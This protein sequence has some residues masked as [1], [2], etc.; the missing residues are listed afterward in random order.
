MNTFW[1]GF[2]KRAETYVAPANTAG[3]TERALLWNKLGGVDPRTPEDS[4]IAESVQLKT[5]PAEVEGANCGS[6]LHFRMLDE[7]LASGFCTNPSVKLD[8]SAR[9][10][11]SMWDAPGT[12]PAVLEVP[13]P[14]MPASPGLSDHI[15]SD[16][17]EGQAQEGG[18]SVVSPDAA[19][20]P[21][22]G[23][24]APLAGGDMDAGQDVAEDPGNAVEAAPPEGEAP[25]KKKP[26]AK[27]K[28]GKGG[29]TFNINV[30]GEKKAAADHV[31]EA[32][33]AHMAMK[34]WGKRKNSKSA[35]AL[36]RHLR[37]KKS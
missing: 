6:C 2:V 30:G 29:H 7:D 17:S 3:Q 13:E 11:C 33:D 26:E 14:T 10:I 22:P 19:M 4:Q 20:Q 34:K 21:T 25:A 35:F 27:G 16:F 32:W 12:Q 37:G 31:K 15:V 18:Q 23:G 28:G 36:I 1:Q 9:M 5:L 8:V 24:A